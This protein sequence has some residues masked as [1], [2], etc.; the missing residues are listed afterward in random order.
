MTNAVLPNV[1]QGD[2]NIRIVAKLFNSAGYST[3]S[4]FLDS[5]KL[6]L[7][8][9]ANVQ[10]G[11]HV[12][13][14]NYQATAG[15]CGS[16]IYRDNTIAC[17]S[18]VMGIHCGSDTRGTS[19]IVPITQ[20]ILE[21]G[22]RQ[23]G[24]S[25]TFIDL[26]GPGSKEFTTDVNSDIKS[27]FA[28]MTEI[29]SMTSPN[30]STKFVIVNAQ[31]GYADEHTSNYAYFIGSAL[32][33]A[34]VN[35]HPKPKDGLPEDAQV[36]TK[37]FDYS[38]V[39]EDDK[40][41]HT[42]DCF[43]SPYK[44]AYALSTDRKGNDLPDP[45]LES[46]MRYMQRRYY[47]N[48]TQFDYKILSLDEAIDGFNSLEHINFDSSTGLQ[49]GKIRKKGDLSATRQLVQSAIFRHDMEKFMESIRD[50]N[51]P[52]YRTP[53]KQ[54]IKD[55]L[56]KLRKYREGRMRVINAMT[57]QDKVLS[58]QILGSAVLYFNNNQIENT[59]G[60]ANCINPIKDAPRMYDWLHFRDMPNLII[61]PDEE[62]FTDIDVKAQDVTSDRYLTLRV[63]HMLCDLFPSHRFL[64]RR[65][66]DATTTSF[67]VASDTLQGFK[68][69]N[70][71]TV[72]DGGIA[73]GEFT[74]SL[75]NCLIAQLMFLSAIVYITK[76][77]YQSDK[78]IDEVL[79]RVRVVVGGDDVV[80]SVH[81]TLLSQYSITIG[82]IISAYDK[83]GIT[84]TSGNKDA[85]NYSNPLFKKF[86]ECVFLK[87]SYGFDGISFSAKLELASI[88]KPLANIPREFVSFDGKKLT[89][90]RSA[91]LDSHFAGIFRGMSL[92]LSRYDISTYEKWTN[93]VY[94]ILKPFSDIKLMSY[95]DAR[96]QS[97]SDVKLKEQ[98][99]FSWF[100]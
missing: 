76:I 80:G 28:N 96:N 18:P 95:V 9:Y 77:D 13:F 49:Y 64:L 86:E 84:A 98:G 100:N 30:Q 1:K 78:E 35:I 69:N 2:A 85:K 83:M 68:Q 24:M 59:G 39:C 4:S 57:T 65:Y 99:F 70:L 56:M 19:S 17:N 23:L 58:R 45:L 81:P 46:V 94:G 52:V 6:T 61:G 62:C 89:L 90:I 92:E 10:G 41:Q 22:L 14:S 42:E 7:V 12:Y 26:I 53:T 40:H 50:P 75:I 8:S 73:S 5:R 74:T 21:D 79:D 48:S 60:I 63:K 66:F 3:I 82:D 44:I 71:F 25:C 20:N 27:I 87:R 93:A 51:R 47:K 97:E 32:A 54:F 72:S 16:P 43:R 33:Q 15:N 38:K 11:G 31:N 36:P 29:G 34:G 55:E 67:N 88:L 37:L 91:K